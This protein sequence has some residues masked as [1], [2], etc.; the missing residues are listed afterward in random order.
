MA[1]KKAKDTLND[2]AAGLTEEQQAALEVSQRLQAAAKTQ[3]VTVQSNLTLLTDQ[4]GS[5]S[6]P[7]LRLLVPTRITLTH[8]QVLAGARRVVSQELPTPKRECTRVHAH[9]LQDFT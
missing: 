3:G 4:S 1:P 6:A 2:A 7:T 5:Y 9:F 8:L